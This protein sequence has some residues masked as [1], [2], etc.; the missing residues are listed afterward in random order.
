MKN[1]YTA[2]FETIVDEK[3]TRVWAYSICSI[4]NPNYFLYGNNIDDFIKWCSNPKENYTLYFHNLKFDGEFIFNYLLTHGFKYIKD[5]KDRKDNTFTCLINDM[6]VFYEIV[7]YFKIRSKNDNMVTIYDSLKILNF[8]VEQ[9]AKD[10]DLPI[11]KLNIDYKEYREVGH[12][13]TKEEVDY[14]KNDVTI[15]A[16]ALQKIFVLGLTSMTIGSDALNDYKKMNKKFKYLFPVLNNATDTFCRKSY[17][18]GFTYLSD[19]YIGKEVGKGIVFDV[20]SLYPS[21]MYNELLPYDKPVVFEGK[22]VKDKVYNLYIQEI[23]CEFEL[24]PNM[25]PTIQ[26][27]NTINFVPNEYLKSSNGEYVTL[28][29]TN[30]DLELFFKH[31]DVYDLVYVGG[32]KFK[33]IKGVFT[34]Y[35]DKWTSVKINSKKEGNTSNYRTAKLMLNSLYGKFGTNPK[36]TTKYPE[37]DE[38]GVIHYKLNEPEVKDSV[39]VPMA[40]FITSYARKKTIETSQAI[41]DYTMKKYG[42]DSYIYSDTDSIHCLLEVEETKNGYKLLDR[43]KELESII[44]I[45]DYKLGAWKIE[46]KFKKGKYLRQKCYIELGYDDKLNVTIA[47]LP[48]KLTPLINFDNFKIGFTTEGISKEMLEKYFK[49]DDTEHTKKLTYKHIKGGI[50]LVETDFTIK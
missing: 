35:I 45:D 6:G 9:I 4:E 1:K 20:N 22:Y 27:K 42:I 29:L 21:V 19:K 34:E 2:D 40:A 11:R 17:K 7:I 46:S 48:K 16:M 47:G 26:I 5:K 37:L 30:V 49:D 50:V 32:F 18:G 39:Y 12:I 36:F 24:K 13:L 43:D 10:F 31:Y 8:S 41:R 25:I 14:I 38:E 3:S 23:R 33:S 44:E 15:M 28:Y